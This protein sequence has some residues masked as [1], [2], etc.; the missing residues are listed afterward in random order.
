M[1]K[2]CGPWGFSQGSSEV[3]TDTVC[4]VERNSVKMNQDK[5][6]DLRQTLCYPNANGRHMWYN[7]EKNSAF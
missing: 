5:E 1:E 2:M 4:T 3:S 7:I 6:S